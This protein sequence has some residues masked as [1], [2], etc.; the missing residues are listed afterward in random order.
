[1]EIISAKSAGFCFGVK[2][3]VD[4]VLREASESGRIVTL[5][6]ITHNKYVINELEEK[7]V[8]VVESLDDPRI[9]PDSIVFIRSHGV[10]PKIY[11]EIH[12]R[13]L[14]YRDCTCPDVA[15]IHEMVAEHHKNGSNIIILGDSSHPEVTGTNG[16]SDYSAS[17][18]NSKADLDI[19]LHGNIFDDSKRYLAVAQTTFNSELFQTLS[20]KLEEKIK[21]IEIRNTI[22]RATIRRQTEANEISKNVDTMIVLGDKKSSNSVKLYEI[23]K[24]NLEKTFFIENINEN[25]LKYFSVSDR[26]GITAGASTP[27][28]IIREALEL[29]SEF[30]LNQNTEP[31][32]VSAAPSNESNGQSFEEMLENGG[33]LVHLHKGAIVKGTVISVVNGEVNVNL[34]YKSD[35]II[36]KGQFADDPNIDPATVVKPGDEVE[37]FVIHVNDKEGNVLLSRTKIENQKGAAD[38]EDAAQNGTILAGRFKEVVK[39]GMIVMIKGVR[40]F[41]P[42]SQVSNRFVENLETLIGKEFNFNII[43]YDKEKRRIVAGRRELATAESAEK[44]AAA[45]ASVEPGQKINGTVSRIADFGAFVD[46]GGVDGLIHVSELSWNRVKKVS[47][48]LKEGDSVVVTVLD[49][50]KEKGKISL[51]L[52]DMALDPWNGIEEKYKEGDIVGGLVVRLVPFGAFIQLEPGLDGLVH[53][54]HLS[55]KRVEKPEDVLRVGQVIEVMVLGVDLEKKKIS[56]SKKQADGINVSPDVNIEDYSEAAEAVEEVVTEEPV[57]EETAVEESSIEEVVIEE[58]SPE[59]E[60]E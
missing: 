42:M 18:I 33:S 28:A 41:V 25:M 52:K 23:C 1:M 40:A 56:L 55:D 39:G 17:I 54:S 19:F 57:I 7:G 49:V 46:I 21:N 13:N 48:V 3:A 29:M 51:S 2:R 50:N 59:I 53:I 11:Q 36:Q 12:N 5:G 15:K 14:S 4:S 34:N 35:G 47:D 24:K 43:Q 31:E 6:P 37:V 44:K 8:E 32:A 26:I 9:T 38:I 30:E 16:Y 27:P 10:P 58:P 22:C 45:F 20:S 60:A